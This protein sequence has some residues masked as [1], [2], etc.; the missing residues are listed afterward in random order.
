MAEPDIRF[1]GERID[2]IQAE[3]R[4]LRGVRAEIAHLRAEMHTEI[5]SLRAE[6]ADRHDAASE[7]TDNLEKALDARFDLVH[8]T[9]ATNLAAVLQAIKGGSA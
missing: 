2:R 6:I 8:Q 9:M 1:L 4:E 7:R 5:S 3:L